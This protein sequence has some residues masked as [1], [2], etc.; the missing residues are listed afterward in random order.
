MDARRFLRTAFLTFGTELGCHFF[1][2]LATVIVVRTLTAPDYGVYTLLVSFSVTLCYLASAGLP[3]AI[4]FFIGRNRSAI[5]EYVATYLLLCLGIG[6]LTIAATWAVRSVLFRTFL[7]ELPA[8]YL[9][10]LLCLFA[11]TFF[12]SFMLSIV[13]GLKNFQLFNV[14]RLLTPCVSLAG[15]VVL[16]V[17]GMLTLNSILAVSLSASAIC[18]G[19]FWIRTRSLVP[20]GRGMRLDAV[21]ALT[22]YGV[23][24]YLQTVSGY[25]VYYI[26][27]Y[28]IAWLLNTEAVAYY[29]IAVGVAT[30]LWYVPNT[31]GMVL[32]PVLAATGDEHS[33]HRAAAIVCRNTLL[34]TAVGA[35]VLAL[36]GGFLLVT[37]YGDRYLHSIPA[38][39]ILLPGVVVMGCYKVLTRDF[40][41]RN[42]QQVSILAAFIALVVNVGLNCLFIPRYGINGAAVATT[43]A[44]TV[45]AGVL[46][47]C[48]AREAGMP[49]RRIVL[50][51]PADLNYYVR[52]F[53]RR[54]VAQNG[55]G[56]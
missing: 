12:D 34:I 46:A 17:A 31:V 3:Q 22:R 42:R 8:V 47:G 15:I 19:W 44:Y 23:K 55:D 28:I 18:T 4:I 37:I 43:I 24:S 36:A 14:R 26:D 16:S 51:E 9:P 29:S 52:A 30:L 32:F 50:A 39:M 2:F 41:S 35:G 56:S 40:S 49:L 21:K 11:I 53:S 38:L 25:L 54:Q 48:L 7:R 20:L 27:I 13:R 45:A 1:G 5:A 33:I 6:L 10:V